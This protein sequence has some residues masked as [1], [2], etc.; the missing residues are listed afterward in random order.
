MTHCQLR[1]EEE[2]LPS[3]CCLS[4]R[5]YGLKSFSSPS[6]SALLGHQIP[7]SRMHSP[8]HRNCAL[9]LRICEP[10]SQTGQVASPRDHLAPNRRREILIPV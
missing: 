3:T 10:P 6:P 4:C 1:D 5:S 9:A 8:A 7:R 2:A